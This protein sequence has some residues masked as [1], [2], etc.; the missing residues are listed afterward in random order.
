M[1]E[2]QNAVS[3]NP[4]AVMRLSNPSYSRSDSR[5]I[6]ILFFRVEQAGS[7][8]AAHTASRRQIRRCCSRFKPA[9]LAT[10]QPPALRTSLWN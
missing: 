9:P 8:G 3:R 2:F 5:E 6:Y 1:I 10:H 4:A 7:A